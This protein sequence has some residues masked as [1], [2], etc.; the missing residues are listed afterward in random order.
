MS[1]NRFSHSIKKIT[2][3]NLVDFFNLE[4]PCKIQFNPTSST[5]CSFSIQYKT[6][7]LY[8]GI[9]DLP[10]EI[11]RLIMEYSGEYFIIKIHLMMSSNYPFEAPIWTILYVDSNM[12]ESDCLY[13][14]I[15]YIVNTHVSFYHS[16]I[17]WSPA[18]TIEKDLLNFLVRVIPCIHYCLNIEKE[19]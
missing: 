10:K 8:Y 4:T 17:H 6:P 5:A 16:Q 13:S 19:D 7:P 1:I 3:H 15:K 2:N 12:D 18:N 14:Q 11:N 9:Q